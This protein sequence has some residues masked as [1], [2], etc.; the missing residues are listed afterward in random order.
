MQSYTD[1]ESVKLK[2]KL[3]AHLPLFTITS[4]VFCPSLGLD[5]PVLSLLSSPD[6]RWLSF[7]AGESTCHLYHDVLLHWTLSIRHHRI[8]TLMKAFF[9]LQRTRR[10]ETNCF[11]KNMNKKRIWNCDC[12]F[13]PP[14][15]HPPKQSH[16]FPCKH[17]QPCTREV[18]N[19]SLHIVL[20]K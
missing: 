13:T 20:D 12:V 16:L 14:V 8:A 9:F 11:G 6:R 15:H 3:C 4:G 7:S 1:S 2:A 18:K 10:I 5:L 19:K 17:A